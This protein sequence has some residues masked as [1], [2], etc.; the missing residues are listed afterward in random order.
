MMRIDLPAHLDRIGRFY[1]DGVQQLAARHKLAVKIGGHP[2]LT[3]V[4]FDHPESA[5]I[6]TLLTVRML[7]RGF[8]AGGA[9]YPTFAHEDRHINAY[10]ASADPIFAEISEAI[11]RHDVRSRIGGPVKHTGFARLA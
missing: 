7:A 11:V 4:T 5:A 10:L 3:S 6:Q 2:A 9:F 8:M 1:R